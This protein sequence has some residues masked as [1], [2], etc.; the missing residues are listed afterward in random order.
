MT[1]IN[2]FVNGGDAA[3]LIALLKAMGI[4]DKQIFLIMGAVYKAMAH[5]DFSAKPIINVGPIN[6]SFPYHFGLDF[7]LSDEVFAQYPE[8]GRFVERKTTI[9]F[10]SNKEAGLVL[11]AYRD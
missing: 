8:G 6:S 10:N 5:T 4:P 2:S 1:K 7:F 9:P 11:W 3:S